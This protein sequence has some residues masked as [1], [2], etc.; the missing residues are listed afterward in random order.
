MCTYAFRRQHATSQN[1]K[2]GAWLDR[3]TQGS[4]S[5]R[6]RKFASKKNIPAFDA[7]ILQ[8]IFTTM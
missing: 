7:T 1:S 6:E 5:T 3:K 2:T 8:L 4:P